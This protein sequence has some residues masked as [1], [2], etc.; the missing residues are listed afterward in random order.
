MSPQ[1][2]TNEEAPRVKPPDGREAGKWCAGG[3]NNTEQ[4][5]C[6]RTSEAV[7]VNRLTTEG[8][9]R[10][11]GNEEERAGSD[12]GR[13]H[14]VSA[15]ASTQRRGGS[16]PTMKDQIHDANDRDRAH[17]IITYRKAYASAIPPW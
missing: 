11:Q 4:N 12:D 16:Q 13:A 17:R 2:V 9:R 10:I 15:A 7:V 3:A 6:R 1:G 8:E 14:G 5:R